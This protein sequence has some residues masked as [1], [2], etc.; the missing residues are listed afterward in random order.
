M[1]IFFQTVKDNVEK[2]KV[3]A[4]PEFLKAS[5]AFSKEPIKAFTAVECT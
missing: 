4:K 3:N 1:K 5:E 2:Q